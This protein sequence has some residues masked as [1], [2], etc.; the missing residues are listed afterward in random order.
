MAFVQQQYYPNCNPKED[1]ADLHKAFKGVGTDEATVIRILGNRSKQQLQAINEEYK[2]QSSQH[3]T[4]DHGLRAEISGDFLKLALGVITPTFLYKTESIHAAVDG[5]GTREALLIDV[6]SQ[7]TQAELAAIGG[8]DKLRKAIISDVSGDFKRTIEELL[9][10]QRPDYGAIDPHQA[11]ELAHVF[12]KAGEGKIGT[13]EKK[14]IEILTHYSVEALFQIDAAYKAK[15]KHG[16][17]HAIS[18]ETSGDFKTLLEALIVPRYEY[19][20]KRLH[21]AIQGLGTDEKTIIYI[22]SILEK[23]ELKEVARFYQENHKESLANAIKGDTSS[24]FR[25]FLITLL[26]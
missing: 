23:G 12:Y 11:E 20:A 1:A 26:E 21:Q 16:L 15:H 2:L 9:K 24:N 4:L 17:H 19:Y 8:D 7:S 18:G 25:K 13:D 5:V 22:F 14:Y 10:A 3:H 6:L